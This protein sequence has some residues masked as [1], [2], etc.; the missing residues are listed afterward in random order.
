MKLQ[1]RIY[2]EIDA[3]RIAQI[4][5][6]ELYSLADQGLQKAGICNVEITDMDLKPVS[7]VKGS[8][9]VKY[10]CIIKNFNVN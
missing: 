6:D 5:Q 2:I 1:K 10:Q 7:I 4:G 8:D 9:E 3:F